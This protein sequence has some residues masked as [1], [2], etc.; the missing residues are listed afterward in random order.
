MRFFPGE[1]ESER[2]VTGTR[3]V[4][5]IVLIC[6]QHQPQHVRYQVGLQNL[7]AA[8]IAVPAAADSSS[9]AA[10]RFYAIS[11]A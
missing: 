6:A 1:M 9:T 11:P 5:S 8:I 3:F 2:G 10:L 4:L 7:N